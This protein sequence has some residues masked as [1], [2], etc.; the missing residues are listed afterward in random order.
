MPIFT[1]TSLRN[2]SFQPFGILGELVLFICLLKKTATKKPRKALFIFF[3]HFKYFLNIPSD[4]FT[5]SYIEN[6]DQ[7]NSV[8]WIPVQQYNS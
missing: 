2:T 6:Q 7:R 4:C 5:S 8:G 1:T 3:P